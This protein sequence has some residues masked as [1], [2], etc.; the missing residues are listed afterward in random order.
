MVTFPPILFYF[1][2]SVHNFQV[3]SK[4]YSSQFYLRLSYF[5]CA[6]SS[7]L[8]IFSSVNYTAYIMDIQ[9]FVGILDI[10]VK[11]FSFYHGQKY[12]RK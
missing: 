4:K 2:Y 10:F 1:M 8:F 11:F 6:N 12:K 5:F 9:Y 7:Q 3:I